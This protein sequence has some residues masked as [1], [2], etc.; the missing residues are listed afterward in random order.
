[1]RSHF[2]TSACETAAGIRT[3]KLRKPSAALPLCYDSPFLFMLF[4]FK[5][6]FLISIQSVA[7]TERTITMISTRPCNSLA[8]TIWLAFFFTVGNS[9]YETHQSTPACDTARVPQPPPAGGIVP[10][11]YKKD[12]AAHQRPIV[13]ILPPALLIQHK[14]P[15][16]S[17]FQFI[18]QVLANG[19]IK[20]RQR[21]TS[22]DD[23][24]QSHREA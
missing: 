21:L 10:Q 19:R 5:Q 7:L 16:A 12:V 1:M 3:L 9:L 14:K 17:P 20:V 13:G 8:S 23:C 4:H 15:T 22:G 11:A 24:L 6:A 2:T 18:G